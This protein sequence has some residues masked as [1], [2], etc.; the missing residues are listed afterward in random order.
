MSKITD[1]LFGPLSF[2]G[3]CTWQSRIGPSWLGEE[4][5]VGVDGTLE[6]P[7][8]DLER[9]AFGQFLE[10]HPS[11]RYPLERAIFAYYGEVIEIYRDAMGGYADE[12]APKLSDSSQ[13]W[14]LLSSPSVFIPRQDEEWSFEYLFET[15]WDVEHGLRVIVHEGPIFG[16]DTQAG[17]DWEYISH[18]DTEGKRI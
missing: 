17:P 10:L 9:R 12:L 2:D 11:V 16:V 8:G 13:I 7:P 1:P 4:I 15:Q 3:Y 5:K 18:F 14:R 6:Q